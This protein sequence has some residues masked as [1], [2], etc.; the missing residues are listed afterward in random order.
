MLK[1]K[2]FQYTLIGTLSITSL[3]MTDTVYA[4]ESG[5]QDHQNYFSARQ[6]ET[7]PGMQKNIERVVGTR[8]KGWLITGCSK[9]FG[10]VLVQTLLETTDARVIRTA[11][12]LRSLED[13]ESAYPGRLLSLKLD[14]TNSQ[15]IKD[16]V[17]EGIQH[18]GRIDVLVNNAGYGL[19]GTLEECSPGAIHQIFETN[20]F[21][22]MEMTRAVLPSMRAQ[23]SGHIINISSV[24]GLVPTPGAGLYSSTKFAVEGLSET[25]AVEVSTFGI[26]VTLIEPGSFRTD[27]ANSTAISNQMAEYE[28]SPATWMRGIKNYHGTQPGDPVKAALIMIQLVEMEHPPLRLPLGKVAVECIHEKAKTQADELAKYEALSLSADYDDGSV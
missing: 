25:L 17:A 3:C 23:R 4:M 14:V 6:K 13:L 8:S 11:R 10:K 15:D 20:V 27:F 5:E 9:G 19:V 7:L 24:A 16:V 22:L 2:I 26:K 18:F 21:G 28:E 12:D 1:T